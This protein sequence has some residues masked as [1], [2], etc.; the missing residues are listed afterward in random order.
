MSLSTEPSLIESNL[1]EIAFDHTLG[2]NPLDFVFIATLGTKGSLNYRA[3]GGLARLNFRGM[4]AELHDIWMELEDQVI[5]N[6]N[7]SDGSTPTPRPTPS[8]PL[9]H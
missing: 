8:P 4:I 7:D 5:D 3:I 9:K 1:L 2:I 6:D